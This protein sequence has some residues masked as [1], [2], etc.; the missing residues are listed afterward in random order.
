MEVIDY[1]MKVKLMGSGFLK[2]IRMSMKRLYLIILILAIGCQQVGINTNNEVFAAGVTSG[3]STKAKP[4][5][6]LELN[7]NSLLTNP[8]EEIRLKAANVMLDSDNPVARTILLDALKEGKNSAARIAVCKA[9][10][11]A[12]L[13]NK[14]IRNR[15]DFIQPLLGMLS[16]ENPEESQL[17]A[18]AML[19]FEYNEIGESLE[20]ITT[21]TSKPV[22]MRVNAV[23]ALKL[24]R[25][26][27]A[28]IKLLRLVDDPEKMVSAEAE[29]A[30]RSLGM[31]V[32]ENYWI[33]QQNISELQS[34]GR[35][36]FDRE[37]VIRQE[38]QMRQ[39]KSE[40]EKWQKEY[41]LALGKIY[42]GISDDAARGKFLKEYL[43]SPEAR[44][45]KWALD[46]VI[47]WQFASGGPKLPPELEPILLKLIADPD[48]E[49][50]LKTLGLTILTSMDSAEPLLAQLKIETDD[51]VRVALLNALGA[52]C[53]HALLVTPA[54][55]SPE[56]RKQTLEFAQSFL[57]EADTTKARKG[58]EVLGKL[59]KP[60][61]LKAEEHEVYLGLL[62]KRYNQLKEKPD[63][64][65]QREL[66]S[67]MA[68][69]C[70]QSSNRQQVS[71]SRAMAIKLFEPIFIEALSDNTDFVRETAVD[72]LIN[73]DKVKALERLR[74]KFFDDPSEDIRK[75]LIVLAGEVGGK[76][77]LP[78]LAEKIGSNSESAPAW[79]AMLKIFD[80]IDSA[81]MKEWV[82]VLTSRGSKIK[83]SNE[84]KIAF[85][86]KAEAKANGDA[87]MLESVIEKLGELYY[88][89]SQFEQ[90]S[91]YLNRQYIGSSTAGAKNAILPK[92][93]DASLR[94]SK[95]DLVVKLV[96]E[97]L[98]KEDLG[99]EHAVRVAIDNFMNKPSGVNPDTVLAALRGVKF[100]GARPKWQQW[101]NGLA[102]RLGKSTEAE[103]PKV[104]SKD[105]KA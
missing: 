1:Y 99:P 31:P 12:G 15:N 46:K 47:K 52:T 94:C 82:D 54:K 51:Q 81:I 21:D 76:E 101:L 73:I 89:T 98:A 83:L 90:A 26:I 5:E 43:S 62:V 80:G 24:R 37:W 33:R 11:N 19:I 44:I 69:L 96:E 56:I 68:G 97:Y 92:L 16:T 103:K 38:N 53:S 93:L 67:A 72:G 10:I 63:S 30:L 77:D 58:A 25:D 65:L 45:K 18:E 2:V 78:K 50:K 64:A 35:D 59:L 6:Q 13:S 41:L 22:R 105:N 39:L 9:F 7:K 84:Q 29:K 95:V 17:A 85:L 8:S 36:E 4:D 100:T 104:A 88:S 57:S 49:V 74:S 40:V 28:T 23:N 32:G 14:E 48:K 71:A 27:Q 60:N 70:T 91:E 66:L 20:S 34:K 79:Q 75:K 3:T 61:G 87:K 86:K 55:I 102:S 42:E